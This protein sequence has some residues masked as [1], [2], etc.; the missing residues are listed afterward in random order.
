MNNYLKGV[1]ARLEFDLDAASKS[2]GAHEARLRAATTKRIDIARL[3]EEYKQEALVEERTE[4]LGVRAGTMELVKSVLRRCKQNKY[5]QH[6]NLSIESAYYRIANLV[7]Y[8]KV[9][10][11]AISKDPVHMEL[12]ILGW[13]QTITSYDTAV[14]SI[15]L[16]ND[17]LFETGRLKDE[18]EN[19]REAS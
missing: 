4:E 11:Y 6:G 19:R 18:L 7:N 14:K 8:G 17:L 5:L 1:I 3:L 9:P 12:R 16:A 10:K 15:T 13:C 2:V